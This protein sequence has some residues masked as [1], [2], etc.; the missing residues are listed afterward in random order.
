MLMPILS[1]FGKEKGY[2]INN[3]HN[4]ILPD[5][6]SGTKIALKYLKY[7]FRASGK[8]GHGIHSPFV[9]D[10]ITQV[11]NDK[12]VYPE[13]K[14]VESL[15]EK[16]LKDQSLL[17]VKDPGAGSGYEKADQKSVAAIAR[18]AVRSK[19]YGQLLFR[20]ARH[21]RPAV[22][23]ELG[24]S[25]GISA[26]YL[27]LGNPEGKLI[28]VEGVPAIAEKAAIHFTDLGLQNI[29]LLTGDFD[30]E[31]PYIIGLNS[32]IDLIYLDGNHRKEPTLGYYT[33][34]LDSIHDVS[35][36]VLDDIH[37]SKE[38]ESAWSLIRSHPSVRC[39]VDLFFFGVLFFNTAFMEKQEFEIRY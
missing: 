22:M 31:L 15:R 4:I 7:Y 8:K 34:L 32:S 3:G 29:E 30:I 21:F 25:L 6:Y 28:T 13:Y 10:F 19:K 12:T 33:A 14:R 16:L 23:L 24:T 39:S 11:L 26:S 35:V 20:M 17:D 18:S 1:S 2:R 27:A 38:M 5:M 36:M 9:F 37:W